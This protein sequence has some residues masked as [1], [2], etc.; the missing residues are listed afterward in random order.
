MVRN[1]GK[2]VPSHG[3]VLALDQWRH[4]PSI[5]MDEFELVLDDHVMR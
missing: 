4:R 2:P 5:E 1:D 3:P